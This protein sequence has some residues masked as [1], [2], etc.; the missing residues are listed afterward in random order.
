MPFRIYIY[1]P[2][3]HAPVHSEA[4][5][6]L[7]K[8]EAR[9]TTIEFLRMLTKDAAPKI[10]HSSV[11]FIYVDARHDYCG[12]LA[13]IEPYWPKLREGGIMAGHDYARTT[14]TVNCVVVN[15]TMYLDDEG[16]LNVLMCTIV[17]FFFK[18]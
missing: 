7:D 16:N 11:D 14:R 9:G 1:F 5:Y 10:L 15:G 18:V 13:D 3:T 4:H 6:H 17:I 12:T 8:F 2:T